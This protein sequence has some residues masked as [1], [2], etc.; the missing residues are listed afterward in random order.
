[1]GGKRILLAEDDPSHAMLI[2]RAIQKVDSTCDVAVVCDG[3]EAID[4]LFATG[5]HADRDASEMPHLI[6]LDLRMPRMDGMQV[7]QVLKRVRFEGGRR[8]P[9]VV[10]LTSSENDA[11]VVEA[12]TR[13]AHS[14]ICKPTAFAELVEAI[15][16]VVEYWLG[17][18]V[19]PTGGGSEELAVHR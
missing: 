11:D 6:L 12:Y 7:L 1:M 13:G 15:R 17:L 3:V 5:E 19:S 2:Q 8:M 16:R 18:N 9:P 10:I 4:Y 14:Y